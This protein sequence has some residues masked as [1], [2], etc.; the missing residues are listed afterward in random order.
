MPQT[1]GSQLKQSL[2]I[3]KRMEPTE[4]EE[5]SALNS[6]IKRNQETDPNIILNRQLTNEDKT[7]DLT[8]RRI[9]NNALP[10]AEALMDGNKVKSD[11]D[12]KDIISLKNQLPKVM[13]NLNK[14]GNPDKSSEISNYINGLGVKYS[15]AL[16]SAEDNAK[17]ED[18]LGYITSL[19]NDLG[20]EGRMDGT[21]SYANTEFL[22]N[23]IRKAQGQSLSVAGDKITDHYKPLIETLQN[24]QYVFDAL[25][26]Y[27]SDGKSEVDSSPKALA[28]LNESIR[29]MRTSGDEDIAGAKKLLEEIPKMIGDSN[30]S[31]RDD[32]NQKNADALDAEVESKSQ[33]IRAAIRQTKQY[34]NTQDPDKFDSD[35]IEWGNAIIPLDDKEATKN[36]VIIK[37][38]NDNATKVLIDQLKGIDGF[39]NSTLA[40]EGYSSPLNI[41]KELEAEYV[42]VSKVLEYFLDTSEVTHQKYLK[43]GLDTVGKVRVS[44]IKSGK[45]RK[46]RTAQRKIQSFLDLILLTESETRKFGVDTNPMDT[47]VA[48][49]LKEYGISND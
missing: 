25:K 4:Y 24:K 18:S 27:T 32:L 11:L 16:K 47:D 15:E 1:L 37:Q 44:K 33:Q 22:I 23:N 2:L 41:E 45:G 31:I 35:F 38:I 19:V 5:M 49:F 8:K 17:L 21:Y 20:D 36:P 28:M 10:F 13:E 42:N 40:D 48:K 39:N 7:F 46:Q 30:K 9:D 34:T 3:K 43:E 29:I 12:V 26:H 6:V 14:Y